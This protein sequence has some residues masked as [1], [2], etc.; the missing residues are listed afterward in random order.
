M[1]QLSHKSVCPRL[2]QN[3]CHFDQIIETCL[4]FLVNLIPVFILNSL[5]SHQTISDSCFI[6]E[7]TYSSKST[8][9][10]HE[11]MKFTTCWNM[12]HHYVWYTTINANSV[13]P[14]CKVSV[15]SPKEAWF[16]CVKR[17]SISRLHHTIHD[18]KG[19]VIIKFG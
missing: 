19:S 8:Y 18:L 2:T 7:Y 15:F 10:V 11:I 5:W 6:S 3:I 12:I 1:E 9:E 17:S 4:V 16:A 13:L 14:E